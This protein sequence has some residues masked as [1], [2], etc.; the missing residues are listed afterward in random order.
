MKGKSLKKR[1][2]MKDMKWKCI[3]GM[4]RYVF[5]L[6]FVCYV[7]IGQKIKLSADQESY[8]LFNIIVK[9]YWLRGVKEECVI[10]K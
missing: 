9:I 3:V 8:N 4:I 2:T 5:V 7:D 1:V 6:F 10:S